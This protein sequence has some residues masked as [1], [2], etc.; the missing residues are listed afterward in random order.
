LEQ[1]RL[2]PFLKNAWI[3]YIGESNTGQVSASHGVVI[4]EMDK[5]DYI[6][7]ELAQ[8]AGVWTTRERKVAYLV[9]AREEISRQGLPFIKDCVVLGDET[10]SEEVRF[11]WL[12]KETFR[13][14]RRVK[15]IASMNNSQM[16]PTFESWSAKLGEDGR[17]SKTLND[18]IV[19]ALFMA[20][21]WMSK[22]L[23]GELTEMN[24][25]KYNAL[26]PSRAFRDYRRRTA[27][28]RMPD[29]L[30]KHGRRRVK[31]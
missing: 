2:H 21:F 24:M 5:A 27:T 15:P 11:E 20:I 1:I 28:S 8:D 9:A 14:M 22:F 17:P 29:S 18:D 23:A 30:L 26:F 16:T 13:Q 31:A 6:K 10:A 7:D 3:I 12:H 4:S 25:S 19:F